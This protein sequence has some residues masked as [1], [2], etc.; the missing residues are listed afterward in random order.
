MT[1]RATKTSKNQVQPVHE[2]TLKAGVTHP[3]NLSKVILIFL[4]FSF[5]QKPTLSQIRLCTCMAL[6]CP[7]ITVDSPTYTDSDAGKSLVHLHPS[8]STS[9]PVSIYVDTSLVCEMLHIR[10]YV[11]F[12]VPRVT[13]PLIGRLEEP[14]LQSRMQEY[15]FSGSWRCFIAYSRNKCRN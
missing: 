11:V 3:R 15:F 2:I 7:R 9:C 1:K 14:L 4:G 10:S 12:N 5:I 13:K 8:L 6:I